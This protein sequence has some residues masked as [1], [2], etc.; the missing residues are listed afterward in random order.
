[1]KTEI[2]Y[3]I[4]K[5]SNMKKGTENYYQNKVIHIHFLRNYLDLLLNYKSD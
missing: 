1:M 3:Q 5:K 2:N 4:N